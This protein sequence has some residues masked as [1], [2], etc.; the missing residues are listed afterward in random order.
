MAL[1]IVDFHS[2]YA[3]PS[4][5]LTTG[6]YGSEDN[7]RRWQGIN[8]LI[9]DEAALLAH[10]EQG[11]IAARVVSSPAEF[12]ADE[13]G[14]V[15]PG[16]HDRINE[17]LAGLV[18]RHKGKV[19]ALA[20]VDVFAGDVGARQ[21]ERAITEFGLHGAFIPSA[22]G[23]MLLDAAEARPVLDVANDLRIPAFVHPV[24]PQP[25]TA[26]MSQYGRLGTLFA[27][28]T[29]NSASLIALLDTGTL[30]D[31]P[32]LRIVVTGLAVASILLTSAFA[33]EDG[34]NGEERLRVLREQVFVETMG[35]DPI[36]LRAFADILGAGNIVA[37]SDWPIVSQQPIAKRLQAAL[38]AAGFSGYEQRLIAGDTIRLLLRH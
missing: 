10:I 2:H 19:Y 11:D 25:L 34:N 30:T 12:V 31:R 8:R 14:A 21:L 22:Q 5:N 29:S 7:R 15:P 27:R 3:D 18:E 24:N 9:Q 20:S 6:D 13:N 32:N 1:E 4:L 33:H 17:R 16:I 38:N 37:G 35:F 26:R 23:D 28:G 36:L